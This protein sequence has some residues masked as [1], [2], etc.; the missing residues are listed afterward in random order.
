MQKEWESFL[1][2]SLGDE[3]DARTSKLRDGSEFI[4]LQFA[5]LKSISVIGAT[6]IHIASMKYGRVDFKFDYVIMDESSKASPAEALVPINMGRNIILIG[7]HK[8]LPPVVTREEAVK[9]KVRDKLEDNGLDIDKEFGES[10][11]EKI[12]TTVE[13]DPA[14]AQNFRMLDIQYRM[15]RQIGSIISTYF[16]D[17][18]LQNPD[19]QRVPGFDQSKSHELQLAK[20]TSMVFLSTSR[21]EN[22]FDNGDKFARANTCNVRKI[23]EVL[24]WLDKAYPNNLQRKNEKGEPAPFTIGII[25]GYRGQVNLLQR[26]IA[27]TKYK[28]FV[29]QDENGEDVP[30]IRINTVDKFQGAEE[31]IIIYDVVKSSRGSDTIGFLSDYRRVNV[32]LSRVK[33]L[34]IVV[35]DTEYL[36]KRATLPNDERFPE[37]KLKSIAQ[38]FEAQGLIIHSIDELNT[39]KR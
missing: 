2:N 19:P 4:G 25:A 30:L 27:L 32:A 10:M 14:K 24:D 13:S 35:G 21:E 17:G 37:F 26:E 20:D 34:L 38:E 23:K 16:Y 39:T 15:P 12:I 7:D 36:L 29:T 22:P 8:Q 33:R 6:C 31:D 18:K 1:D 3:K 28:N 9:Q 11:F 5:F